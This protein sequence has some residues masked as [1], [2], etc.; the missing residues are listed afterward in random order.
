MMEL[1]ELELK[2]LSTN[3]T[4]SEQNFDF[5][6]PLDRIIFG[7]EEKKKIIRENTRKDIEEEFQKLKDIVPLAGT[8][9]MPAWNFRP[10]KLRRKI[11][12]FEKKYARIFSGWRNNIYAL[13][14][15]WTLDIELEIY[16]LITQISL[17][18]NIGLIINKVR[19]ILKNGIGDLSSL[20]SGT[21][22]AILSVENEKQEFIK[23]L[24]QQ[25]YLLQKS[26]SRELIPSLTEDI[27]NQNLPGLI[28]KYQISVKESL[29]EFANEHWLV[30]KPDYTLPFTDKNLVQVRAQELIEFESFPK[31]ER[32]LSDLKN[33][34]FRMVESIHSDINNIDQVFYFSLDTAKSLL[35]D[36]SKSP[37]DAKVVAR[38]G[39]ERIRNKIIDLDQ[40]AGFIAGEFIQ[41]LRD[42]TATFTGTI[43]DLKD[44][45]S[46]LQIKLRISKAKA[47]S[48]SRQIRQVIF[49][50]I[51]KYFAV[52]QEPAVK[53]Y[54]IVK[55]QGERIA[56]I[57]LGKKRSVSTSG[58]VK[59]ILSDMDQKSIRLSFTYQRLFRIE[60][61]TDASLFVGRHQELDRLKS[62]FSNWKLGH[63]SSTLLISE[64][65]GGLT[66]LL[67]Q[68][69]SK[70]PGYK[71]IRLK[72]QNT[73]F[74]IREFIDLV[75]H[76][77][78][79]T[80]KTPDEVL[81]FF[82]DPV[83]KK[84][85][86]LEDLHKFYLR[87]MNGFNCLAW[88]LQLIS[89]TGKNTLWICSTNLYPWQ[90]MDK[91]IHINGY[92]EHIVRLHE[93][94]DDEIIELIMKRNQISGYGLYFKP[95]DADLKDGKY[96]KLGEKDQQEF[97]KRKFFSRLNN[98]ARSNLAL[99][100]TYWLQ[101]SIDVTNGT[102]TISNFEEPDLNF[103]NSL[104]K[105]KIFTLHTMILHDGISE[106]H[107]ASLKN[108]ELKTA[109]SKL[110][111]LYE[112]GIV[113]R[114]GEEYIVNPMVYRSLITMLKLKNLIY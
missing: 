56:S 58:E 102:I 82:N 32:N 36:E 11:R 8:I 96:Q 75:N 77:F 79:K 91:T 72:T 93:F 110:S 16:R 60:P 104:S 89:L 43:G 14:E 69:D 37:E 85:I 54:R 6:D 29:K 34:L 39:F 10:G 99:A 109:R 108:L 9:E 62:A 45:E 112:N 49:N 111:L 114:R 74:E 88:I 107:F 47:V 80:F 87:K 68:V 22:S 24:N 83:N 95:S 51:K 57:Y 33:E 31:F 44:N 76:T 106:A 25:K 100:L 78:G 5:K 105:E 30:N 20:A 86:I 41:K 71:L 17:E 59:K 90:L 26:L 38:E 13:S 3:I 42:T 81:E 48:R 113:V 7:L 21:E 52:L 66:S 98:Y 1:W 65:G 101:S 64:K 84:I 12:S 18:E 50:K 23:L 19:Q 53:F 4:D 73:I 97:L 103:I 28:D 46:L 35:E 67:N 40:L 92:F 55:V 27:L 15:D 61:L 70:L 2:T 94:S 63:F